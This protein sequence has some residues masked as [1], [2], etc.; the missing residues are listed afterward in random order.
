MLQELATCSATKN[1]QHVQQ[2]KSNQETRVW[3]LMNK[4]M[5]LLFLIKFA[6]CDLFYWHRPSEHL[7][8]QVYLQQKAF[9]NRKY[10]F[11]FYLDQEQSELQQTYFLKVVL[12][13]TIVTA[14]NVPLRSSTTHSIYQY[15]SEQLG[16][17]KFFSLSLN[18]IISMLWS[19]YYRVVLCQQGR[20]SGGS[21]L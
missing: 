18:F 9:E 2:Q 5:H 13:I 16:F 10:L 3:T 1:P 15:Q 4:F 11:W 6:F 7:L 20:C 19:N 8:A 17:Y 12:L 14:W 21:L